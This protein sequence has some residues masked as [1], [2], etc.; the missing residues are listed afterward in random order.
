[1]KLKFE[2][3]WNDTDECLEAKLWSVGV[4]AS[5]MKKSN[6]QSHT[7]DFFTWIFREKIR[8]YMDFYGTMKSTLTWLPVG[9]SWVENKNFDTN[10]LDY[11]A[12]QLGEKKNR[13]RYMNEFLRW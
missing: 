11:K 2:G 13:W 8:L 6:L 10:F 1:M 9:T 4:W 7:H 5:Q 3:N 12:K